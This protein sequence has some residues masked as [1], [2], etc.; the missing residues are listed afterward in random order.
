MPTCCAEWPEVNKFNGS[1]HLLGRR[2]YYIRA[3]ISFKT[4]A[5]NI[6]NI[7]S[8]IVQLFWSCRGCQ[9]T[10]EHNHPGSWSR[11]SQLRDFLVTT[12]LSG[13]GS[14]RPSLAGQRAVQHLIGLLWNI[15]LYPTVL[16]HY[17]GRWGCTPRRQDHNCEGSILVG[18]ENKFWPVLWR[19]LFR[20]MK[21][22]GVH[23]RG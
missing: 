6:D 17:S 23:C 21:N 10:A 4:E 7:C 5:D 9:Y 13:W 11:L 3:I 19:Q 15:R 2:K 22:G 16:W 20:V 18:H 1:N 12:G 14:H 8:T